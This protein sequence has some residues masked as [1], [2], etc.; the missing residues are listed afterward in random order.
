MFLDASTGGT[1][2]T[3]SETEV[4][5]LVENT[6]QNEHMKHRLKILIEKKN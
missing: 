1:M 5:D 3:K 6:A 2:K 4:R